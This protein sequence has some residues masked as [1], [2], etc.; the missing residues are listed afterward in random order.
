MSSLMLNGWKYR[1]PSWET[2]LEDAAES[3]IKETGLSRE[4]LKQVMETLY[5]HRVINWLYEVN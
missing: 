2:N 3:V 1:K 5:E 4:K